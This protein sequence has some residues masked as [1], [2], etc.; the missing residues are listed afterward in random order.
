MDEKILQRFKGRINGI[1]IDSSNSKTDLCE[2]GIKYPTD[3]CPYNTISTVTENSVGHR[4]PY[5]A[6]YDLI[7]SAIRYKNIKLAEIG[8][9]DNMSMMCWREYFPNSELYGFDFDTSYIDKGK[10]L[11]LYKTSYDFMDVKNI[12]SI[13]NGL[14]K[15]GKYDIIIEDSTHLF[16]DQI[17]VCSVAHKYLNPG[18]VLIIE[19][20]F[21]NTNEE[22][23]KI[24]LSNVMKYYSSVT[25]ITTEHELKYSPDWDN[26]KLLILYRNDKI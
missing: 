25:F 1:T 7:F 2:L 17:R 22:Q 16:Q 10:S 19:D 23:Y 4:H 6:V 18:G 11:N 5:T 21:R 3:K 20:I 15:Y 12:D 24:Y 26:D 14:N 9:L 8:V 13:E